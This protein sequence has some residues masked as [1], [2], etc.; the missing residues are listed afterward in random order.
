MALSPQIGEADRKRGVTMYVAR[1][2]S[3]LH[4]NLLLGNAMI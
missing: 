1:G 4:T 2:A 3:G